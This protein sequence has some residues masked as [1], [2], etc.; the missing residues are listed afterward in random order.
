MEGYAKSKEKNLM[1]NLTINKNTDYVII[2]RKDA[3]E[4]EKTAVQ[5]LKKYIFKISGAILCEFCDNRP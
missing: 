3:T 5:N 1:L 4:A 2:Y